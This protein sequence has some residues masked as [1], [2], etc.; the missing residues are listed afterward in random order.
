ME[1]LTTGPPDARHTVVLAHGAGQPMDGPA[2]ALLAAAFTAAGVRVVRFEFPYMR[3]RRATGRGAA[4]DRQ[5]VLEQSWR[6]AIQRAGQATAAGPDALA[7]GGRSMGGRIAS[8]VADG[9]G[10][11][12]LLCFAYPFHPPGR[13]DRLRTAH[14]ASLRTPT[15]ILQGERDPFGNPAEVGSYRLSPA[16]TVHWIADGDHSLKPR[17]RSGRTLEDNVAAAVECSVRFLNRAAPQ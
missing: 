6:D 5:P 7:I 1:L 8:L 15:L 16:V 9:C 3:R 2:M 12:A 17:K 4:P 13:P 14:L 11:R 10:V